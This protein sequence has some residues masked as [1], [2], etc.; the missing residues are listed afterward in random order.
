MEMPQRAV[1]YGSSPCSN[2]MKSVRLPSLIAI[3]KNEN[4]FV[5][6]M[7]FSLILKGKSMIF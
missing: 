5:F 6:Y 1:C 7:C 2:E 4:F 3:R